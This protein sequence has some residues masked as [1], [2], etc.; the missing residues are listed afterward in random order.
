MPQL[1]STAAFASF[2]RSGRLHVNMTQE[3][4]AQTVGKTR[5]WVHDVEAGKVTPSLSAAIDV[6]AALGFTV[7]LERSEP[8]GVLDEVF[9]D[10]G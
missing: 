9:E 5:R 6:A 10:L 1:P 4:L 8:S 2:V 7:H 3:D